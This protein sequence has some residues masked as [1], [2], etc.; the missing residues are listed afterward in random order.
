[1]NMMR[2]MRRQIDESVEEC[3]LHCCFSEPLLGERV[4][5]C[6]IIPRVESLAFTWDRFQCQDPHYARS[7]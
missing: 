4:Y 6:A 2:N 3:I 7:K 1:M 5:K